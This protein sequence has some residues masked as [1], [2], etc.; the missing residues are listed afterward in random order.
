MPRYL[1]KFH[2]GLNIRFQIPRVCQGSLNNHLLML[3]GAYGTRRVYLPDDFTNDLERG[4]EKE[5][6][7][8]SS[9]QHLRRTRLQQRHQE[10]RPWLPVPRAKKKP[11]S[12]VIYGECQWGLDWG[13]WLACRA[14][15]TIGLGTHS[16]ASGSAIPLCSLEWMEARP[17]YCASSVPKD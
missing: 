12:A 7:V 11:F 1:S 5:E 6:L 3:L 13:A 14:S 8:K 17:G 2:K 15:S 16:A 10:E 9:G 4:E